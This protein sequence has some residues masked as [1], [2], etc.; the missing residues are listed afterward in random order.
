MA[1]VAYVDLPY[2]ALAL[3]ALTIETKRPRRGWPVLAL[4]LPAG[5]LRPEAWLFSFAYLGYLALDI[6]RK[7]GSRGER[8][9]PA[10]WAGAG[11]QR[12]GSW[13]PWRRWRSPHRSAWVLFD[14]RTTGNPPTL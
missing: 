5:L 2:I 10:G 4:L 9:A 1:C 11:A 6:K 8:F 12:R 3:G 14:W 13:P 7:A